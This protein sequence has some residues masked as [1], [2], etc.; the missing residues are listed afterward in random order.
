MTLL[1]LTDIHHEVEIQ[2]R[3]HAIHSAI[4]LFLTPAKEGLGFY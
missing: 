4:D 2:D 3:R 1:Q